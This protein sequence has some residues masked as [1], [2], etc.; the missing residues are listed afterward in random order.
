VSGQT[1]DINSGITIQ[2]SGSITDS[3]SATV[4]NH[5]TLNANT[6]ATTLTVS[7]DN[8]INTGTIEST[9][10]TLTI[11]GTNFSNSGSFAETAGTINLNT[12]LTGSDLIGHIGANRTGGSFNIG[13]VV[14]LQGMTLDIG[15]GGFGSGGLSAFSGTFSNGTL[16]STGGVALANG[17]SLYAITLGDAT[18]PSLSLGGSGGLSIYGNLTLADGATLDVGSSTLYFRDTATQNIRSS[19]GA[20]ATINLTGGTLYAGYGVSGQTLDINSGITIQGS[21]SITDSSSATVVNRGTLDANTAATTLTVYPDNFINTGTIKATGGTLTFVGTNFSNSGSFAETAGTINLDTRLTGSDL[22]GHIGANR[23]GGSFNISGVVDLQGMTLDIGTG[24]FGSGGLSQFSGTFSNGT[25]ISTG[26]IATPLGGGSLNAITLGDATHLSFAIGSG[27]FNI[28]GGLTLADGATLDLGSSALYFRE[29]GTQSIRTTSGAA[30]TI[31][32]TGGTLYA[33]YGVSGQTLDINGGITIAGYGTLSDSS[34]ATILNHGTLDATNAVGQY[35]SINSTRFINA[36]TLRASLGNLAS[37]ATLFSNTG[38]IDLAANTSLQRSGLAFTNDGILRGNGSIY[39]GGST[40]LY[41]NGSINVGDGG[42]A[43]SGKLTLNGNLILGAS[44]ILNLDHGG[45]NRGATVSG[46]DSLEVSGTVALGGTANI[47]HIGTYAPAIGDVFVSVIGSGGISGSFAAV[48]APVAY[49][50]QSVGGFLLFEVGSTPIPVNMWNTDSS[51]AWTTPGNWSLGHVPTSTEIALID[52][53]NAN[54]TITLSSGTNAVVGV[55]DSEALVLSGGSLSTTGSTTTT[56]TSTLTISGATLTAN[57]PVTV[58]GAFALSSGTLNGSGLVTLNNGGTWSGGSFGGVLNVAP[59]QTLSINGGAKTL[60]GGSIT[61]D[62][63]VNW[64]GG[65]IDVTGNA[66]IAN[67]AQF[68]ITANATLG[69]L[70]AGVG[71]VSFT[72]AAG[73]II[74]V[75]N[76][77][78]VD[79]GSNGGGT[80]NYVAFSNSGQIQVNA[81]Q[82]WINHLYAGTSGGSFTSATGSSVDVAS[83]ATFSIG[84]SASFAA[85]S[86]LSGAGNLSETHGALSVGGSTTFTGSASVSGGTLNLDSAFALASLT[87]NGGTANVNAAG[88]TGAFALSSGSFGGSAL[89]TLDGGGTWSGGVF[90]GQL[91]VASGQTLAISGGTK[92]LAGGTL[93]ND[94]IVNWSGGNIDVTGNATIANN[95]QFNITANASLGDL[96]AGVGNVSFTNAAGGIIAVNNSTG[97]DLGT[98]GGGTPNY[99][100]FSNS[101]QIQVATGQLWINHLYAGTSGGSFTGA[102][103]SS[104]D[105]ASGA[106]FSVGGSASF[107]AGSVLSGAGSLVETHGALNLDGSTTFTGSATVSG[108]TLNLDSAFALAS[109]TINGGTA[110]V[111][112]AGST[113][114]FALSSG[115]FG[116]SALLTLN[117]GGTWSGGV[118]AGLLDVASGQTLVIS[119]GSKTLA[120]GTLTNDGIVNWSGGNIDVTGNATI[121][122]NAQFNITANASLGDLGAGVGNVSFTNAAGGIIA[123]NNSTG[124]DLGSNGGGTPNFVAFSNS[125]QIQVD[126]GQLWINHLY[127]GTSG[128]SFTGASGSSADVASGATLSIGGSASFAAGSVLSG[129]GSLVETHGAL[130]LDGSTTFTGSATVSGGTL[131]LDSAF[132]LASLTI[133]GGTANVNVAGTTGLLT[134]S[135]GTL[136]GTGTLTL[137]GAGSSWTGGTWSGGGTVHL[138]GG[139]DLVLSGTDVF[140]GHTLDVAAAATVTFGGTGQLNSGGVNTIVNAGTVNFT[141]SGFSAAGGS[142]TFT[143]TATLNNLSAG[144]F[145]LNSTNLINSGTLNASTGTFALTNGSWTNS[146]AILIP[147]GSG[148]LELNSSTLTNQASGSITITS[149]DA[150][151]I[152]TFGSGVLANAGTLTYNNAASVGINASVSNTGTINVQS[153]TLA[154]S[155]FSSNAGSLTIASGATLTGGGN[156]ANTGVLQ[157]SGTLDLGTGT[158]TNNGTIEPGGAGTA[159]TLTLTGNLALGSSGVINLEMGGATAGTYD[160]LAVSGDAN[161]GGNGTLNVSILGGYSPVSGDRFN[162]ITANSFTGDFASKNLPASFTA[163]AA[164]TA[165]SIAY[166]PVTL[167]S[168]A[169]VCWDGGGDHTNWTDPANWSAD[170]LPGIGDLVLINLTGGANVFLSSGSY[171]IKG[172]N[173]GSGNHLTLNGGSLA[174]AGNAVTSTL[175]G[176]LTVSAGTLAVSG[177]LNA[178]ILNLSG[179]TVS[180]AGNIT[181]RSDFNQTGGTFAP[182][183]SV[184]LTRSLGSFSFGGITSTGTV[185]LVTT[186][187][188]DLTLTGDVVSSASGLANSAPAIVLNSG[189]DIL[190]NSSATQLTANTSGGVSL[191]AARDIDLIHVDTPGGV[192]ARSIGAPGDITLTAGNG[193]IFRATGDDYR[194]ISGANVTLTAA[195]R[196]APF[197]DIAAG[198]SLTIDSATGFTPYGAVSVGGDLSITQGSGDLITGSLSASTLSFTATSGN[199]VLAPGSTF[200]ATSMSAAG[201]GSLQINGGT[202]NADAALATAMPLVVTNGTLN[203]SSPVSFTGLTLAGATLGGTGSVSASGASSIS[204][205]S[206]TVPVTL[207]GNLAVSGT[208]SFTGSGFSWTSG[209]ISGSGNLDISA[210]MIL[211]GTTNR[212][213]S[214]PAVGAGG[215]ALAGGVLDLPAGSLTLNGSGSI[216]SGA[217]LQASGGH[218]TA[219]AAL[220]NAGTLAA[221]NGSVVSLQGGGSHSGSFLA[222]NTGAGGRIDFAGGTH[223][224]G[225]GTLLDGG[226]TFAHSGGTLL[227]TGTGSGTT[228]GAA[229]TIDLDIMAFGGTGKLTN[230]GTVSGSSDLVIPG[231]FTNLPGATA[232]LTDVT[233]VGSLFNSGQFNVAGTVTVAGPVANQIDGTMLIPVGAQLVKQSGLFSWIGGTIHGVGALGSGSLGFTQGGTFAFGGT[234]DRVIDGMN[235]IFT[236]LT[237]PDG[238]LTV[239]SGSLTLNGAT[240]IPAGVTLGVNGGTLT[241]NGTLNIVGVFAN[242]GG[243]FDGSGAMTSSGNVSLGGGTFTNSITNTGTVTVASGATFTQMFTNQGT[244]NLPA[245]SV[246]F[247]NGFT[248]SGGGT[249]NLGNTMAGPGNMTVGGSGFTLADGTVSGTGTISGNVTIGNGLL[250]PGY[251]P[252]AL[253]ISGDLTLAAGSTTRIEL[254]G[255]TAGNT[256]DVVSVTGHVTLDGVLNVLPYGSYTPA[257]GDSFAFMHFGSV[258]GSF[259]S[260]NLPSGWGL[261]YTAGLDS[262]QLA[263]PAAALPGPIAAVPPELVA[264]PLPPLSSIAPPTVVADAAIP[265]EER[266][267]PRMCR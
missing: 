48:N 12:R 15:T 81:G 252:G 139:T 104:A 23:T 161:L 196:I 106:T 168:G 246:S 165:Y 160:V 113:G 140:N 96:S 215:L 112:A 99:V 72:N 182:T 22:V 234:G 25:L 218:L 68:N 251:S 228:I 151:P 253:T 244:F 166:A 206:V 86:V 26:G 190:L 201:T 71:N 255:T 209:T 155:S 40:T 117:G 31:N 66:T 39:L 174:L 167:C 158:L 121:A 240:N 202:A 258:S 53:S 88:S 250:N 126:A 257:A 34:P 90:A 194:N 30:A 46:Y 242:T 89:L 127:A 191:T 44:S 100:A 76:S 188:N 1:L 225:D 148:G 238:S 184:D 224:F 176:N 216:A 75:N 219:L 221:D 181:V 172:L 42:T 192:F 128:G 141:G 4:I 47:N 169:D 107:A 243:T 59:N 197:G 231:D 247:S 142:L 208:N 97:A 64:S 159:G 220:D 266:V 245:G 204:N 55:I 133:N 2:G 27:G 13:G 249:V 180:G 60:A 183:G 122:N 233:I 198:G 14:D 7:P 116:G 19:S 111:N 145:T 17:G 61:N 129:G 267:R 92:T 16:I 8:F 239:Q 93:T 261:V 259:S 80:P 187:N 179:G 138:N 229:A 67:N 230:A 207:D 10:G 153:G 123:V 58:G 143:N 248:Q 50:A 70:G 211:P 56:D 193:Q 98:N 6:A 62:G 108:G 118:F 195:T 94:G 24:G 52:R 38:V 186:G 35:L 260:Q 134:Q 210:A 226:G 203:L 3:S 199:V 173:T 51:G 171:S 132:A 29:S 109:L 256:Y 5:G 74:T 212:V 57:G 85:G 146:G 18:H 213:V 241:N 175:A 217:T 78:G 65:N 205:S 232:D 77:S 120:G 41:N 110:N 11:S 95:A 200:T 223:Q 102:S 69:D 222:G 144:T 262:L 124:A 49:T 236:D 119:G 32:M 91:D 189:R 73:G 45:L 28:Y 136:G 235:F 163:S 37:S 83:G 84:G 131:N 87:I 82:L 170:V 227:L 135:S 177:Q 103:G 147:L 79:L 36:G 264:V 162:G 265:V 105:V 152:F 130:S 263:I 185:R 54:P 33:G 115:S 20:P 101:G 156:L 150:T 237:V 157:G 154:L 21:G 149:A 254:G 214:G 9:A 63:V 125:G 43:G 178:A 164:G 114:A 137:T